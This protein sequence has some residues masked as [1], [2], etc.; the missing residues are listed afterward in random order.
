MRPHATALAVYDRVPRIIWTG[1]EETPGDIFA[2]PGFRWLS[3]NDPSMGHVDQ[4]PTGAC[5]AAGDVVT[6][7]DS[8]GQLSLRDGWGLTGS[9]RS[10]TISSKTV[11]EAALTLTW[12]DLE[13]TT[14]P[15]SP[16]RSGPI[17]NG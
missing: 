3:V 11:P 4:S 10:I 1:G 9:A 16:D 14:P 8:I 15:S 6:H 5:R 7:R 13:L 17:R 12:T 2:R